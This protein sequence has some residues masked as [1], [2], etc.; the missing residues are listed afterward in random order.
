WSKSS[1]SGSSGFSGVNGSNYSVNSGVT[2]YNASRISS[3]IK[4]ADL[5]IQSGQYSLETTKES[6]SL[7]I[8]N[9]YLQVLYVEEQVKNTRKQIE[10]TTGQLNLASE[11]LVLQVISIADY[12]QVKSQL[13]SE[14]LTFANS[15]S[16]L[17]IAKINLMQLMELPVQENFNIAHPNLTTLLNQ[18]RFPDVNAVYETALSIKPQV[19]NADLNKE[20]A[21]LDEKIAKSSYFPVLSASAGISSAYSSQTTDPYFD[22]MNN[23]IRPSAGFSLS[24]PIY[25]RKQVKTSVAV[26][27]LG[28]QDAEL[29]EIDTKNQLRKSIEQACLDVTSAQIEYEA[30]IE[31][32]SATQESAALSDEKFKQGI[33]NSVDYL[34]SKTNLIVAESQLLQSKFNLIFSYKI[35]DFYMGIPLSI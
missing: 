18:G 32:Y 33:I 2:I 28:Y 1:A 19:K 6:I 15:E 10:S 13:A 31:K 35:L 8:L 17:A 20:I 23:G 24:I 16:Q 29:S 11:R 26:A 25:Q 4:Q 22:Q 9:A 14:K 3:Q 12:S 7:S 21:S 5:E 30:S 27:K 34:V